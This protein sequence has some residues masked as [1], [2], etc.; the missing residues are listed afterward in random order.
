[1]ARRRRDGVFLGCLLAATAGW[2]G[3]SPPPLLVSAAAAAV[4]A[5]D[6]AD[7]HSHRQ[8]HDHDLNNHAVHAAGTIATVTSG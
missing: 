5:A 4:V 3:T 8:P 1:M 7:V 2:P 6:S